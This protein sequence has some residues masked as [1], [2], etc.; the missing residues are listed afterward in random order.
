MIALFCYVLFLH[1]VG[2]F[3]CQTRWIANNKS[4]RWDALTIH[5]LIYA[6]VLW[7]GLLFFSPTGIFAITQFVAVNAVIHWITDAITS[8]ITSYFWA[9]QNVHGFFVTIGFDQL[10]HTIVLLLSSQWLITG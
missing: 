9:K 3:I 6:Q 8:R 2:D 1:W 5:V 10:T 7:F 4:K